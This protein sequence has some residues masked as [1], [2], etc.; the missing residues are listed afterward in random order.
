MIR[1]MRFADR[2]EAGLLLGSEL[3]RRGLAGAVVLGLARGGVVVAAGVARALGSS[4]DVLVVRKLGFP[5][6]PELG[7]GAVAE[8]GSPVMNDELVAQLHLS[9]DEL[10]AVV[11]REEAELERR[12]RL[13]RGG[14]RLPDV[15]GRTVV[16][17]DDGLAT[18][19]T[20]RAAVAAVRA[21]GAARVVLA[22]PVGSPDTAAEL[23]ELADEVVCLERP[24]GLFSIGERYEDFRQVGDDEVVA[25][26]AAGAAE[27]QDDRRQ[28]IRVQHV[29]VPAGARRLP[30]DLAVPDA[31]VG[32]VVFAHGSGSSRLSPRNRAVA[33]VLCRAGLATLLFDLLTDEEAADRDMVF[34]IQLLAGRLVDAV[35]WVRV[36]PASS[37]LPVGLF[38]ASTGAGAAL[39]AAAELG[40]E[41]RAVV[42]RGG[43]PDL[44]GAR[45]ADVRCPTLLLVG[46][47]DDT[48]LELNRRAAAMLPAEHALHVVPGATHLF[49]E[50][51]A[52]EEVA[53][54]AAS[55][56][57]GVLGRA[58]V[59]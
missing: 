46:G 17:V 48:V 54:V 4:M 59:V 24:A 49:E 15:T 6:Q 14:R 12:V 55:F 42:S 58:R 2:T 9:P 36:Q 23:A 1:P 21:A 28:G 29:E 43:R 35:H 37:Q 34:D 50:H 11:R 30:G 10:A 40:D 38:G 31:A 52:L 25:L 32:M 18:G 16:V 3:A 27:E 22:A 53:R 39:V 13:Y 44:A 33:D 26:L 45:L 7:M 57:V 56:L 8:G 51:G 20:A 5:R 41:I 19:Y 47:R